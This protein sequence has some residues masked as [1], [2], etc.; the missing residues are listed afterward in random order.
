MQADDVV[1]GGGIVVDVEESE[2]INIAL[3]RLKGE[4]SDIVCEI[5][6]EE[7][8]FIEIGRPYVFENVGN[9]S[10]KRYN[11]FSSDETI[12]IAKNDILFVSTPTLE[13]CQVYM[14]LLDNDWKH[15]NALIAEALLG[16]CGQEAEDY[17]EIDRRCWLAEFPQWEPESDENKH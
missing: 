13:L 12:Q 9:I 17:K 14:H 3:I 10:Y 11:I 16:F 6:S 4:S 8:K 2:E 1:D 5:V 15:S 7:T